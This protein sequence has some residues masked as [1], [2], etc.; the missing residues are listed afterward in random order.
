ML[1]ETLFHEET[2]DHPPGGGLR[3]LRAAL[4]ATLYY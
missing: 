3:T 2:D 1:Y 4:R